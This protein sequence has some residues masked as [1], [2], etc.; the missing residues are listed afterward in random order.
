MLGVS[1]RLVVIELLAKQH[2]PVGLELLALLLLFVDPA[3]LV[4]RVF[5]HARVTGLLAE[6]AGQPADTVLLRFDAN[7]LRQEVI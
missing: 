5:A 7:L 3:L 2:V 6:A 4:D 1:A